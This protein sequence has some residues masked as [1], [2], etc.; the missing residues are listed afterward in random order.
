MPTKKH[1]LIRITTV[2]KSLRRLLT[3]QLHYMNTH[4]FEVTGVS[5]PGELLNEVQ[6]YEKVPTHAIHM[7][8]GIAPLQDLVSLWKLYV[9]LKQEQPQIV[10]TH[11]PKAGTLGM[12]AAY[13]ARV[14]VRLHTVAGLPLMEA[15]GFKRKLLDAVERLTYRYATCVYP[16][17]V[18]LKEFIIKEKLCPASKL[19]VIGHG[20]SN[21]ID[22]SQFDPHQI[23]TET[24]VS[25][26]QNLGI[27]D[28]D[29]VFVFVGRLVKDKGVNEL[30]SAFVDLAEELTH[31]HLVVVGNNDDN[32]DPLTEQSQNR[33]ELHPKIHAVGYKTNV[34][35]YFALADVFVFPSYREGFPNVVLQAAAMQLCS[36]VTDINGSNEIITDGE[37]G[38]VIPVK[39]TER[40]VEKMQWCY[41]NKSEVKA[42]GTQSRK[43]IQERFERTHLWAL[44]KKEYDSYL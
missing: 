22:T 1:K 39:N 3:G 23:P 4:G 13:W 15:K 29:F 19:K 10:H 42:M 32:S 24:V 35:D 14:P 6:D 11:T 2:A 21:G 12:I 26:K 31:I 37:N 41:T 17:S 18:N 25:I 30:L 38:F 5:S 27:Q 7:Q 9:Y 34:V 16:N 20:S 28:A 33:L 43:L 8:R 36:I 40:L 44:I